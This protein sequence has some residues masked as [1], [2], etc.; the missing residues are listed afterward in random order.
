[1][2]MLS[3]AWFMWTPPSNDEW[4]EESSQVF[5]SED[6]ANDQPSDDKLLAKSE[7]P[8]AQDGW[9]RMIRKE[10]SCRR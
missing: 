8:S 3:F 9:N 4:I 10:S 2:P 1:M 5:P 7:A 6:Q